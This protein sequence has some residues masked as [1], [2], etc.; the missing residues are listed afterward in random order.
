MARVPSFFL[1][2][3]FALTGTGAIFYF[4]SLLF[5]RFETEEAESSHRLGEGLSTHKYPSVDSDAA[6]TRGMGRGW[7]GEAGCRAG[8]A[9]V[10]KERI[11]RLCRNCSSFN[12]KL[13]NGFSLR[14]VALSL[15]ISWILE[16]M[17]D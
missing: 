3:A 17:N 14:A 1:Y 15:A 2:D 6:F 16:L 13:E 8:G 5:T 11:N 4:F 9:F 12:L 7:R 10:R